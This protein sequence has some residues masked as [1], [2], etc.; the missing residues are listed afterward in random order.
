MRATLSPALYPSRIRWM[1]RWDERNKHFA[2][3][4]VHKIGDP[5]PADAEK[6][7]KQKSSHGASLNWLNAQESDTLSVGT[8]NKD[9]LVGR[10]RARWALLPDLSRPQPG[11]VFV[12]IKLV[13]V[14]SF[15]SVTALGVLFWQSR[16]ADAVVAALPPISDQVPNERALDPGDYEVMDRRLPVPDVQPLVQTLE[17]GRGDTLMAMLTSLGIERRQAYLAIESLK[18]HYD[19]RRLRPGQEVDVV[20][21]PVSPLRLD[22]N[23][24]EGVVI[25][26]DVDRKVAVTRDGTDGFKVSEQVMELTPV[27]ALRTGRIESSLYEAAV[28]AGVPIP[29]LWAMVR[30][31]SYDIDFQRDVQP[32]DSF[33]IFWHRMKSPEGVTVREGEVYYAALNVA[34]DRYVMYRFD[35]GEYGPEYFN[36]KGGSVRKALLK[37]PIDGARIS[38]GYG[39]RR[40]PILGYNRMHR[41]VDFAARPGTPIYAAGNGVVEVAGWNGGYGRYIRLRHSESFGTAYAHMKSIAR[42]VNKGARVK[43]GQV[44]GYVG[45]SGRST[46]P[47]LHYEILKGG[48][49]VNPLKVKFP[50]GR[51]L[52]GDAM[53]A[54]EENMAKIDTEVATLRASLALAKTP[55]E[56]GSALDAEKN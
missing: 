55:Q 32:G 15:I 14:L 50:S 22:Q 39:K 41:G 8:H 19:P 24:F 1:T 56:Q 40:H 3:R 16:Q 54:F 52:K 4:K 45:S 26:T 49:Q 35:E 23:M 44:I 11:P 28:D 25:A 18:E 37:T 53:S 51:T 10:D 13:G 5:I 36:E 27:S 12:H 33:E 30:N 21:Q 7:A 48:R 20:F 38:S 6:Q 31:L 46:G 42:G 47:H 34:G 43:Q 29:V 17:V 2:K 9:R